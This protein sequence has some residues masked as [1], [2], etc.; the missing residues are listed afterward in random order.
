MFHSRY[1]NL[2][3]K[4]SGKVSVLAVATHFEGKRLSDPSLFCRI[5]LV[6]IKDKN[7]EIFGLSVYLPLILKLP[8]IWTM[9][10]LSLSMMMEYILWEFILQVYLSKAYLFLQ[11]LAFYNHLI[12]LKPSMTFFVTKKY[13]VESGAAI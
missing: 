5:C 13:D 11:F 2:L 9:L 8:E 1:D 7:S 10:C 4:G 3:Q 12:D 6:I